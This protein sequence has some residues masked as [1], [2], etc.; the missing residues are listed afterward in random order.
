MISAFVLRK[1][2]YTLTAVKV[3][4]NRN[5]GTSNL[6]TI[7][8]LTAIYRSNP[9]AR[10]GAHNDFIFLPCTMGMMSVPTVIK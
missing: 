9:D 4:V 5:R 1:I 8:P 6:T 7:M 3:I 10:F 2:L